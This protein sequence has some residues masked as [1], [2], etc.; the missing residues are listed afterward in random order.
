MDTDPGH[1][2]S[3]TD[4]T[5]DTPGHHPFC[6]SSFFTKLRIPLQVGASPPTAC[7]NANVR[8][9]PKLHDILWVFI[10]VWMQQPHL[11]LFLAAFIFSWRLDQPDFAALHF[12]NANPSPP[13]WNVYARGVLSKLWSLSLHV[14]S[15]DKIHWVFHNVMCSEAKCWCHPT[16]SWQRNTLVLWAQSPLYGQQVHKLPPLLILIQLLQKRWKQCHF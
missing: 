13:K 2:A 11:T 9:V 1:T 16:K 8:F 6:G 15:C 3:C 12:A 7:C 4:M 5:A 14:S 10:Q